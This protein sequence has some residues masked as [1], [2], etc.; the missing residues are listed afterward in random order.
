MVFLK[1]VLDLLHKTKPSE[2]DDFIRLSWDTWR[3]NF[4]DI[5][6]PIITEALSSK[7]VKRISSGQFGK[8]E[9][10]FVIGSILQRCTENTIVW[11][12]GFISEDVRCKQPPKRICAVRGPLTRA[13]LLE[14]GIECPEVY[15]DPALL[16][17]SIYRPGVTDKKYKLGIVP[18]YKDKSCKW[19]KS[20]QQPEILIIDV[21]N[22]NPLRVVDEIISCEKIVSSSLHGLIVA[23]A[24]GIPAIWVKFS[25]RVLGEGF[26]FKDYFASVGRIDK[27]PLDIKDNTSTDIIIDSFY[28]YRIEFDMDK[29]RQNCPFS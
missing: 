13:K 14:Q 7:P 1:K 23:D 29:L 5:L 12:S 24:Y 11:G 8:Y 18:H 20:N 3:Y 27:S 9:H 4:G 19:L 21:Q 17:P 25:D 15:G 26:K 6:N 2:T 28:P 22:K 10:Y 16:L